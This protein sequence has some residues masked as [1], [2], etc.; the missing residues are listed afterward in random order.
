MLKK[1]GY[2]KHIPTLLELQLDLLK[3]G[4]LGVMDTMMILP[5]VMLKDCEDA[6]INNMLDDGDAGMNFKRKLYNNPEF[7][8]MLDMLYEYYDKKGLLEI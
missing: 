3:R 1:L 7:I 4:F 5:V 8:D 6:D 2:K